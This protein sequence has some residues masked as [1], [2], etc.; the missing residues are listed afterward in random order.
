[1][2]PVRCVPALVG[3][4]VVHEGE[5]VLGVAVVVL[6]RELD[7]HVIAHGLDRDGLGVQRLLALV[8]PLHE[9]DQ[10]ALVEEGLLPLLALPLVLEG[11]REALF[12]NATP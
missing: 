7:I 3:V 1:L 2:K 6:E 8:E 5:R 4:D 12:R 11:D 9:L 10:P